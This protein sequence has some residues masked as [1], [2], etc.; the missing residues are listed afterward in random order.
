[1]TDSAAK[2]SEHYN[3]FVFRRLEEPFPFFWGQLPE[4][5]WL[6]ALI[7]VMA[8]ALV[9]V[10]LM[11]AKDARGVGAGWASFLGV[12]RLS[13]YAILAFVFLL[14]AVQTY[15]RTESESKVIVVYDVSGSMQTSDD[16]PT[17]RTDE[18]LTTRQELVLRFLRDKK[19]DFVNRLVA[20]NPVTAYRMG[21]KLADEYVL[22]TKDGGLT[23][24]EREQPAGAEAALPPPAPSPLPAGFW[25]AWLMPE[26]KMPDVLALPEADQKRF[27]TLADQNAKLLGEKVT[28]GT[29]LGDSLMAIMNKELNNRV[30]GV[31][32]FTDGRNNTGSTAAFRELEQ[33][34]KTAKVPLFVVGVGEDRL[35]VKQEVADLRV[36]PL[37]QPEDKFRVV[38]QL[39]GQGLTGQ[40]VDVSLEIVHVRTYK[41]KVKGKDGKVVEVEKEEILP[42][43]LIERED[44]MAPKSARA[45]ETLGTKLTIKPFTLADGKMVPAQ[46]AYDKSPTPTAEVEW[47]L[48]AAAFA[49][50]AGKTLDAAKKWEIGETKDDSDLRFVVRVPV[51]KRERL[52]AKKFHESVKTPMKVIKKPLRV[53]MMA[54][55]ANRD[56]QFVQVLLAREVAKKRMELTVYLQRPPGQA[57]ARTG[58]VQNVAPERLLKNFPTPSRTRRT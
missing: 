10:V 33:R 35:K 1:M 56:F 22:L 32:V 29:N 7:L 57:E 23:R 44:P 18:R 2:H 3:E 19:A 41:A 42:I 31:V 37:I 43:E 40:P 54:A 52:G 9:Y 8:I 50:A 27:R 21:T 13:V 34:S 4:S 20:T 58:V 30:Q 47:Q 25:S 16:L 12:L 48:D 6:I 51:D 45:K 53:L 36:P 28:K 11:Y 5:F 49:A 46:A 39:T 26:A 38:T 17:G 24:L 14:P 55:G 15:V